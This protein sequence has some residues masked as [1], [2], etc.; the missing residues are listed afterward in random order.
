MARGHEEE[1]LPKVKGLDANLLWRLGGFAWPQAPGFA[2][3]ALLLVLVTAAQ[4]I[5]PLLVGRMIDGPL[6]HGDLQGLWR[7]ALLYLLLVLA[8]L[9]AQALQTVVS[10]RSGALIIYRLRTRLFEHL[11]EQPAAFFD[12]NPVGRL[13][14]RV[15]Y[16][17]EAVNDLFT[18]GVV[19]VFHDLGTLAFVAVALLSLDWRLGL[20]GLSLLPFLAW[21]TFTLRLKVRDNQRQARAQTSLLTAFWAERLASLGTVQAYTAEEREAVVQEGHS[22]RLRDLFLKQ[23]GMNALFMPL[24]EL[25]GAVSVALLLGWGGW[26]SGRPGGP[27][28]GAVVAAVLYVQRLYGPLRELSDK[29]GSFQT[30]F[31]CAERL[32]ALFDLKPTL[33]P[34]ASPQALTG[35]NGAVAFEGVSFSYHGDQ[36]PW[37]LQDVSFR[38]GAGERVAVVGHTGSGKSTLAG[39]LL[40]FHDPQ[41]G[42]VLAGGLPLT[43]LDPRDLRRHCALVLQEPF[44]FSGSILENVRLADEGVSEARVRQA[45]ERAR[46]DG[47]IRRLPQG[48]HT[49]LKEGGKDLSSGQRQLLSLARAL[50][51]DPR[52]LILDEAT[53]NVDEATEA[54]LQEALAEALRGRSSL[55][56]AHRLSTIADADRILVLEGGRLVQQGSHAQLLGQP[57]A[58]RG[59]MEMQLGRGPALSR[60]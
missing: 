50:A 55:I 37:A 31:A 18:D 1:G 15:I 48:Y 49:P 20:I 5:G 53:A 60:V 46:A 8:A 25:L 7:L 19:A 36:G 22:A 39:L 29:L 12:V 9:A 23:I 40:R 41:R 16:D 14:T 2:L 11:H 52:L 21:F 38:L 13:M 3:A 33:Q 57:G 26:L 43:E 54:L 32:F 34:P 45:C 58:Y 51:F 56:I 35:F 30:G 24:A 17:L 47:F 6:A 28:L 42:R 44:L 27:S 10:A 59:L 4:Q